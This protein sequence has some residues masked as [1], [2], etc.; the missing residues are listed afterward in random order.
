MSTD[1]SRT[2][3]GIALWEKQND[4][5]NRPIAFASRYLN[6]AEKDYSIGERELLAVVWRLEKVRFYIYGKVVHLYTDHQA[7]APLIKRNQAYRR[8]SARLTRW[9]DRL[10]HFDISIKHTAG[11]SL[12]LT[13]YLSSHP[14]EEATTEETHDQEYV[15]NILS[16]L[17]KA[18]PN[19]GQ[20]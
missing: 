1:A 17:F 6:D 12:V 2:G 3:L 8:Y 10:A 15:I 7:L 14:T 4:D 13:D 16:E 18:K 11:K 5:A 9:V 19:Y 20:L